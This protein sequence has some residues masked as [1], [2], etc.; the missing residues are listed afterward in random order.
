MRRRISS[1]VP[2]SENS[3]EL[4]FQSRSERVSEEIE[5]EEEPSRYPSPAPEESTV[6]QYVIS[7][8]NSPWNDRNPPRADEPGTYGLPPAGGLD[9]HEFG[10]VDPNL[11]GMKYAHLNVPEKD[12]NKFRPGTYTNAALG[13]AVDPRIEEE[14]IASD[15]RRTENHRLGSE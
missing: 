13:I 11:P 7:N 10:F 8:L 6:R 5:V 3:D 1:R 4:S 15:K 12:K 2:R 9:L 14:R